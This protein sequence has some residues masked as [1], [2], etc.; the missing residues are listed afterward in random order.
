[1]TTP[2]L[3]HETPMAYFKNLVDQAIA[4]Q[5]LDSSE[6]SAFYLV[7]LLDAFIRPDRVF[8]RAGIAEHTALGEVYCHA[9]NQDGVRKFMLYKLV[10]DASLFL[11]GFFP[12]G[13]GGRHKLVGPQ[14]FMR[15]GGRA[16]HEAAQ[17]ARSWASAPV[18]QEIGSGFARFVDVLNE[19]AESCA[20]GAGQPSLLTLYQRWAETGSSR[21]AC[22]LQRQG[23]VLQPAQITAGQAAVMH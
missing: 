8:A 7:Q 5:R 20:L 11:A 19:V 10:G 16:Y 1:M 18:L 21:T 15:L 9:A 3:P 23:I 2:A 14:Y 12:E 4:H 22:T 6:D 13:C 17:A